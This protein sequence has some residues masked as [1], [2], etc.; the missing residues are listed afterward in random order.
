MGFFKPTMVM[1]LTAEHKAFGVGLAVGP[2]S[3]FGS[4][5]PSLTIVANGERIENCEEQ[6]RLRARICK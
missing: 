1:H 6:G 3:K 4:Q 5:K 2:D